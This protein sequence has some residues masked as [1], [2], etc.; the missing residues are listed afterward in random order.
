MVAVIIASLMT[1]SSMPYCLTPNQPAPTLG[2]ITK[3]IISTSTSSP[4]T[5]YSWGYWDDVGEA[6]RGGVVKAHVL[7]TTL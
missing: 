5:P 7:A 3:A 6:I 4:D 1:I 2:Q